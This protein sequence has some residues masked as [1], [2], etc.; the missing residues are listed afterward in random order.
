MSALSLLRL[1]GSQWS[2]MILVALA[3]CPCWAAEQRTAHSLENYLKRL[4]Y[5]S[6]PLKYDHGNHLL[7]VGEIEGKSRDFMI[8]T[9]CTFT[10]VDSDIAR[11]IKT[12]GL[13]GVQLED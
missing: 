13:S 8:D 2:A 11:K 5:E 4:G 3:C 7:A 9:G 6:I 1:R 10:T 12:L